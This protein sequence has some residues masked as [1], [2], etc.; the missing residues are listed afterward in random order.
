MTALTP[1]DHPP[2][3]PKESLQSYCQ[4]RRKLVLHSADKRLACSLLFNG[5]APCELR[6]VGPHCCMHR[7]ARASEGVCC[8]CSSAE[9]PCAALRVLRCVCCTATLFHVHGVPDGL[10]PCPRRRRRCCHCL[11]GS[12]MWQSLAPLASPLCSTRMRQPKTA[13]WR[14][15]TG[16]CWSRVCRAG[17]SGAPAAAVAAAAAAAAAL[18][19]Q[20]LLNKRGKTRFRRCQ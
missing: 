14:C 18:G 20:C 4:Y 12:G 10:S 16:S 17:P 6:A 8:S 13:S 15:C 3:T 1:H 11:C 5:P 7:C 9:H 19:T 2:H